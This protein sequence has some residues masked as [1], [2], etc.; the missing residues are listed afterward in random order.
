MG[1]IVCVCVFVRA[2]A[3]NYCTSELWVDERVHPSSSGQKKEENGR[4]SNNVVD[5]NQAPNGFIEMLI[6]M[7]ST[8]TLVDTS[9]SALATFARG[10]A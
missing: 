3:R 4:D 1:T 10:K 9:V 8:G 5:S 7:M 6:I 2:C